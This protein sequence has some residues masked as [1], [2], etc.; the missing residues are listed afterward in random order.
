M[1][2]EGLK[3]KL[4]KDNTWFDFLFV[5]S[6]VLMFAGFTAP[7]TPVFDAL[8]SEFKGYSC[9]AA[10]F[11]ALIGLLLTDGRGA[12]FKAVI[13]PVIAAMGLMAV[14]EEE[15]TLLLE[16][17][18]II[19]LCLC[20]GI[21][22]IAFTVFSFFSMVTGAT[23]IL[24]FKGYIRVYHIS[25]QSTFGFR[26]L[27]GLYC[28][29]LLI[30]AS[31]A[32]LIWSYI[33]DRKIDPY[34]I[35]G[36]L[37][38]I[39]SA[40]LV[41]AVL[42]AQNLAAPVEA[43][44]YEI[45]GGDTAL[46]LQVRMKGFDDYAFSFGEY[47]PRS[48][49][50][51]PSGD[52]YEITIDSYGVTKTLCVAD[53][54]LTAGNYDQSSAAHTWNITQIAGTPYFTITN[55]ETGLVLSMTGDGKPDLCS[56]CDGTCRLRIGSENLDLYEDR[57][58]EVNDLCS[59]VIIS[60][61]TAVYTGGALTPFVTVNYAG[62]E[63]TQGTDYEVNYYDNYLPGT[64]V[65]EVKG[66]GG[67]NGTCVK[68]FTIVY[69]D[70]ALDDPFYRNTSDYVVR[71]YRMAYLRFPDIEEVRSYVQILV[72]SNRTPDSVIWEVYNNGG[73]NETDAQFIEAIYRL[74]LLRNGSRDELSL[75]IN[76]LQ[77]GST[78]EDVIDAIS[79]SPDYQNIWHN[80]GI[81]YR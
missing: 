34:I 78:R 26:S 8:P 12:K 73:F 18:V 56:Y 67:Y 81:G 17:S 7:V 23:F 15:F 13:F 49:T 50:I 21:K 80:F 5:P 66:I 35:K 32:L 40:V 30:A 79:V 10:V 77:S 29:L 59:A 72:G 70:P 64:A 28:S 54:K 42:K 37:S 31:L 9:L 11:A 53:G 55:V 20:T 6:V 3:T 43:G 33:K 68:E 63:L 57:F 62:R 36:A 27:T 47:K 25:G 74:M 14:L 38:V 46:G 60:E 71:V 58:V 24:G 51:T 69:G 44:S 39:V 52:Y 48:F 16:V 19:L 75:W 65:I 41:V 61:D 1:N 76:E 45:Y 4:T 2:T 22:T